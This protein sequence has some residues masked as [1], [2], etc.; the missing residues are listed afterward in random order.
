M[1]QY[2]VLIGH[3]Q[4]TGGSDIVDEMIHEN[5]WKRTAN[6]VSIFPFFYKIDK[7]LNDEKIQQGENSKKH[8]GCMKKS[9]NTFMKGVKLF[10]FVNIIIEQFIEF[11]IVFVFYISIGQMMRIMIQNPIWTCKYKDS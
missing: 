3:I 8:N 2:I 6:F 11:I 5:D 4:Q 10:V 1:D 9:K 7:S